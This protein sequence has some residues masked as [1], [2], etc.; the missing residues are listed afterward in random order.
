LKSHVFR[1]LHTVKPALSRVL[2]GIHEMYRL[3]PVDGVTRCWGCNAPMPIRHGVPPSFPPGL[4]ALSGQDEP[5]YLW[6]THCQCT[7]VESWSSLTLSLPQAQRFWQE[8]AR[9]RCLPARKVDAEGSAAVLVVLESVTD[10]A[11]LEVVSLRDTLQVV[12]ISSTL[13]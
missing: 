5:I 8:H 6:C 13:S 12:R 10:S 9:M 2:K 4:S 11:R 7:G 1:D 3:H